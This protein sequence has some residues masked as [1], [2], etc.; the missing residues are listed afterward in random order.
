MADYPTLTVADLAAFSGRAE[1]S[2][3]AAFSA[4]AIAQATLLFKIA[5]C[6]AALPDDADS[7]SL[8]TMAILDYADYIVISQKYAE[9]VASPFTSETIGSYSYAKSVAAVKKGESTGRMWFD[10]AVTN[11]GVCG[12]E[13]EDVLFGGIEIFEHDAPFVT[14]ENEGNIRMLSPANE[15]ELINYYSTNY[16]Q[17]L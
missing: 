1:S 17:G 15:A 16:E 5:T 4:T 8:A 12:D 2:Y 10:L 14:T 6:L 3:P 11:L 9:A 13:D 7:I